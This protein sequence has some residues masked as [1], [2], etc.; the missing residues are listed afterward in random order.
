M[1]TIRAMSNG[2][3]YCKEHLEQN[4]YYAE[5]E[6]VVGQWFGKGA[7]MLGLKNEVSAEQFE[8]VRQ[9]LHPET[10]EMLRP[11]K[12][13]D[14]EAK[15]GT[16]QS[17]GRSLYDFTFSAPKSISIMA[18]IG[19]DSRLIE[20]HQQAVKET[21]IEM[22]RCAAT[23]VRMG[24]RNSDRITG[25]LVVASFQHSSSRRLDPQLHSHNVAANLVY[26]AVE[27]RW[28]ALQAS[29]IYERRA[30]LTEVYR[31]ILAAKVQELGYE[32]ENRVSGKGRN[33]G[34]EIKGISQELIKQFSQGSKAREQAVQ[35]FTKKIGREPSDNEIAVLVRDSRPDKLI[36]ISTKEVRASWFDRMTGDQL[37]QLETVKEQAGRKPSRQER[38]DPELSLQYAMDHVFE[39]L[40]VANDFELLAEA[41]QHGRGQLRL[42]DLKHILIQREAKGDVI[43]AGNQIAT[44]ESLERER[45][46]IEMVNDGHGKCDRLGGKQND[47]QISTELNDEQRNVIDFVCNSRDRAINIEGAAGTGKTA[48]LRELRRSLQAGGRLIIAV[49]P[50]HSATEELQKVGFQNAIT[51]ERLLQDKDAQPHVQGRAI[52]VDEAGMVGGKQMHQLLQL[53]E[54]FGARLVFCGDVRQIPAVQA[55]DALRILQRESQLATV[56]LRQVQRQQDRKYRSAIKTLRADP[57]KGF[58]LLDKMGA[59]KESDLLDRPEAVAAAYQTASGSTLCVC[60]THEEISRVTSAIRADRLRQGELT[61]NRTLERLEPIDWTEAQKRDMSN[62][63]QGQVL[64][65][66]RGTAQARRHESFTVL[67]QDG[68]TVTARNHEGKEI[69]LTKKQANCFS[70]F[71]RQN[72]DVAIGDR[73]ALQA[74]LRYGIFKFINSELV[75]VTNIDERG[76]LKLADGRTLPHTFRQFTHGYAVTAHKS[77]GQTVDH[78]IISGD[79][80]TRELFYVAASRGR[81][82]IQ[83]FTGDKERL[84]EAIGLSGQRMSAL[85]LLRLSGRKVDRTRFAERPRTLVQVV[86]KILE[87]AWRNIPGLLFGPRFAPDLDQVDLHR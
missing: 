68:Q 44:K 28:K 34:F 12:S 77:Q 72:V 82:R 13:A 18:M 61:G 2:S 76:N 35:D 26:D 87:K 70:V 81:H 79:S 11:R 45:D 57:E 67:H 58:H 21:L 32:I 71:S 40:S 25:N 86:G 49:A 75:T 80:M 78:V 31:N 30:Y 20:A 37:R 54:R 85:E 19:G 73:L 43:R 5:G 39:R 48:T 53:A 27:G 22:E 66:H 83:I 14:R 15:D 64:V 10:G 59:V 24:G 74:N 3:G 60:P 7:A 46:M 42:D 6:K 1:L 23:R 16:K 52:I 51:I 29:G 41:L 69:K 38:H 84:R 8:A 55:S 4:D 9:G 50:T 63:R 65:F 33:L 62:F 56:S 47:Y 17:E 36:S